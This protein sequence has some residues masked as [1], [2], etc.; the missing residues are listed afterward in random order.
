M[1]I[2][3]GT[4]MAYLDLDTSGFKRG[5]SSALEN[6]Q[7]FNNRA[8]DASKRL[9]AL[10]QTATTT[11]KTLTTGLTL[12]LTVIGGAAVNSAIQ[13]ESAFAGVRKTVDATEEEFAKLEQGIK[14]M[15][16]TMPQSASDIAAV[17][18]AAGQLG[19]QT[20]SILDF[21]KT[22]IMLGD[23]TNLSSEEAA[24]QLARFAN[25]VQM[26]QDNFDR[27]GS[28]VVAL[29]NNLA[30][31]EAEIVAMGMRLAGAGNQINLTEAQIMSFAGALSS[32]GIEAEA[33]GTAFSTL[34]IELQSAVENGGAALEDF[35]TVADMTSEQFAKAFK[36]DAAGAIV[37]FIS[38]LNDTERLGKSTL[39]VVESLGM[40]EIRLRD[41]LLRAAGAGDLL[42]QS[43]EIGTTAWEEN[44]ALAN[45]AEQRYATMASRL[46]MLKNRLNDVAVQVGEILMPYFE[47]FV[48]VL[49]NLFN[50]L[51][52]LDPQTKEFV[53]KLGLLAAALGPILLIFGKL[54]QAF[55]Q[56]KS[57]LSVLS[58]VIKFVIGLFTGTSGL[59]AAISALAGPIGILVAV[60]AAFAIAWKNDFAGIREFTSE[61]IDRLKELFSIFVE[62]FQ[63]TFGDRISQIIETVK[64]VFKTLEPVVSTIFDLIL[65][66]LDIFI[67]LFSGDL[68]SLKDAIDNWVE[69][70]V[71]LFENFA[72]TL[73]NIG[74]ILVQSLWNGMKEDIDKVSDWVREKIGAIKEFFGFENDYVSSSTQN[75]A[76]NT[77]STGLSGAQRAI[78]TSNSNSAQQAATSRAGNTYIF[79]SPKAQTPAEQ[80][81][82]YEKL[83]QRSALGF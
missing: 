42:N 43:L 15:A 57:V 5:L 80:K 81:Q 53:V 74:K 45:E 67:A 21:T 25:I 62:H 32:V 51:D 12:P 10:G 70:S 23:A 78:S 79:N 52:T 24:T 59:G 13:F 31:T 63:G 66:A 58:P 72:E 71:K 37:A 69:D 60:I 38:G 29:G 3:A 19:I 11:G 36:E 41:T 8:N 76:R 22:M 54:I 46:A 64:E 34:M 2:N 26:S 50:W 48:G 61:V 39:A 18:E 82:S 75:N 9:T 83:A 6:F 47:K 4:A 1:A 20:D 73:F 55:L 17:A 40:T 35:A 56:I 16:K 49:E 68:G 14:D 28:S 65:D 7:V 27:L 30:T 77:L 44:N 33:G